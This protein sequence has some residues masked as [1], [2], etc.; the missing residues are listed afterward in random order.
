MQYGHC[1]VNATAIAMSSLY[2][3]GI[4]PAVMAA[5]SKAQNA[6]I[7]S[8]AFASSCFSL[9]RFFMSYMADLHIVI[10]SSQR[11]SESFRRD[12]LYPG[13][14]FCSRWNLVEISWRAYCAGPGRTT[15]VG[16]LLLHP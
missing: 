5:L 1:V 16:S 3:T 13:F 8:G 7:P 11:C 14:P 6:F 4:A 10:A 9:A 2:L 12:R 15:P